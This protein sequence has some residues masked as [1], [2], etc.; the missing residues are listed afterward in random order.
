MLQLLSLIFVETMIVQ[1]YVERTLDKSAQDD[2]LGLELLA[3]MPPINPI[4]TVTNRKRKEK[5]SFG[6]EK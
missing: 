2:E 4:S 5:W 1:I 6:L 3:M